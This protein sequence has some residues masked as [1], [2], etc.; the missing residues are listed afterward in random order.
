MFILLTYKKKCIEK[1]IYQYSICV[2]I[3]SY[4]LMFY[5]IQLKITPRLKLV[6]FIDLILFKL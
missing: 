5:L 6:E 4:S 2:T 3:W 1:K